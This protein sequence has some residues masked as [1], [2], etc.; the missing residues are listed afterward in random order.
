MPVN[1][2]TKPLKEAVSKPMPQG[3]NESIDDWYEIKCDANGQYMQLKA[4]IPTGANMIGQT[5]A[6]GRAT[7][8]AGKT[9]VTTAGTPVS[10]GSQ[11]CGEGVIVTANPDN[12]GNVYVF[13]ADGTKNNVMPLAPGDPT[14]YPV[15]NISAL[16]VD[17]DVSGES[18]YWQG[19]M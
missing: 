14:Y 13:P 17:A 9:T 16:S 3:W 5:Q 6:A 12:T 4:P 11:P 10:L 7:A 2:T 1:P 18:V 8:I 15:S 19:A